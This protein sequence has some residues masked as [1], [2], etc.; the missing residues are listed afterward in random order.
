MVREKITNIIAFD[1]AAEGLEGP[2]STYARMETLRTPKYTTGPDCDIPSLTFQAW[3]LLISYFQKTLT[4]STKPLRIITIIS[5]KPIIASY[6]GVKNL[7]S[8]C[9]N[10]RLFEGKILANMGMKDEFGPLFKSEEVLFNKVPINFSL[11]E[12]TK[13]R[14]LDPIFY[15]HN[16]GVEHILSNKLPA[17]Y[18]SFPKE[19]DDAIVDEWETIFEEDVSHLKQMHLSRE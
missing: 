2:W 17:G 4:I 13:M 19:V 5:F 8:T 12:P 9:F 1:A 14:Y 16:Y 15:A 7:I 18:H 6:T 11:V 10:K 3:K